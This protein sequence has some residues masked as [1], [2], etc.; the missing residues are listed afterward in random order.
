MHHLLCSNIYHA[1]TSLSTMPYY[2]LY[3]HLPCSNIYHHLRS[4]CSSPI[5]LP[6]FTSP[7]IIYHALHYLPS[8][9]TMLNII[10]HALH[11]LPWHQLRTIFYQNP[12]YLPSS[13]GSKIAVAIEYF[14]K[15]QN[16]RHTENCK[17][18]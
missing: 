5:H 6:C 1:I 7:I 11:H 8:S 3:Y 18:F 9:S 17:H 14:N 15:I 13:I 12:P 16:N 2:H 4:L 10:Y